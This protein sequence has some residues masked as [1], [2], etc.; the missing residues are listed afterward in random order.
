[1]LRNATPIALLATAA[2]LA[3]TAHARANPA[4]LFLGQ[5]GVQQT[6]EAQDYFSQR[7]GSG[8]LA[9][10]ASLQRAGSGQ[11][12]SKPLPAATNAPK[13]PRRKVKVVKKARKNNNRNRKVNNR[14]RK[15]TTTTTTTT[16]PTPVYVEQAVY[17]DYAD[18]V[19]RPASHAR[20]L[21]LDLKDYA[22]LY[23][24]DYYHDDMASNSIE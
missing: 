24:D 3:A 2:F 6:Q 1:M 22:L 21:D 8:F 17:P 20:G 11:R 4:P 10:L 7:F 19:V 12:T 23:E 5:G 14:A 15:T 13:T 9:G 16:T 18:Y